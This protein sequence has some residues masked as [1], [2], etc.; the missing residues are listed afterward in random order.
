MDTEHTEEQAER[1]PAPDPPRR[2]AIDENVEGEINA[3][4]PDEPPEAD[5]QEDDGSR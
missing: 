2:A 4:L 5:G 1:E 3:A